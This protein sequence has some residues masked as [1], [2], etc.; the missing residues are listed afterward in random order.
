MNSNHIDKEEQREFSEQIEACEEAV[1]IGMELGG[2]KNNDGFKY[3]MDQIKKRAEESL[4]CLGSCN[5]NNISAVIEYQCIY[6][7][8]IGI[9]NAYAFGIENGKEALNVLAD[10]SDYKGE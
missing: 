5:P 8:Y 9:Y 1:K 2:L 7:L 10:I 4:V 6:K 3:I